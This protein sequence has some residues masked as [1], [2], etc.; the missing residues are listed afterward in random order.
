MPPDILLELGL[1]PQQVAC[2][3]GRL[4]SRL[5]CFLLRWQHRSALTACL[6]E[7]LAAHPRLV[8]LL[9]AR[10]VTFLEQG[11]LDAALN[12]MHQR[13]RLGISMSSQAL[14]ARIHLARQEVQTAHDIARTIVTEA[15]D[16]AMAWSLLGD[17][18]LAAGEHE[19]AHA[20]YWRLQ[21]IHPDS[22]TYLLGMMTI[23][24]ARRDW[25]AASAYA[26]RLQQAATAAAPLSVTCLRQLRDYFQA[27][28][29]LHR[30]ADIE[31]APNQTRIISPEH[32]FLIHT[33][34]FL[35]AEALGVVEPP[36]EG[37]SS[38]HH[39]LE[40]TRS[41]MGS[42]PPLDIGDIQGYLSDHEGY[43]HSVCC[44]ENPD[45]PTGEHYLTVTSVVMDLQSRELHV[46]DGP[47]CQAEY[48]QLGL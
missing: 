38:T 8:S 21:D 3:S 11:R 31:A 42:G 26:V 36:R 30:V 17:V 48:Q 41:L 45:L 5:V 35:D 27:S 9:D 25:V 4:R 10:A 34:H 40:R 2:L 32:G 20:A 29:E 23:H 24:H 13:H 19:A 37:W 16:K 46:S 47:P 7:L 39:R 6:D 22:R 44:H 14:L 28:Q 33:N 12:A 18:R 15:T 1:V 43:P